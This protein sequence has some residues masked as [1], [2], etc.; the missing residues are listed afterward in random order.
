MVDTSL[1]PLITPSKNLYVQLPE[2]DLNELIALHS[3]YLINPNAK[4]RY[5]GFLGVRAPGTEKRYLSDSGFILQDVISDIYDH[6]QKASL[7]D[8]T[9]PDIVKCSL[10]LSEA[11]GV[12]FFH[13]KELKN[14]LLKQ[15][16][17]ID[18]SKWTESCTLAHIKSYFTKKKE[19]HNSKFVM[20][21]SAYGGN[22]LYIMN[23]KFRRF[24]EPE[25][26]LP[27]PKS[28]SQWLNVVW[29][30]LAA[31]NLVV[32]DS[33]AFI[34][35]HPIFAL[36]RVNVLHKNQI[37]CRILNDNWVKIKL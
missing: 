32:G 14:I 28:L 24:L 18:S 13:K 9:N 10:R 26:T 35:S 16:H 23:E 6:I 25:N 11:L 30:Y 17:M 4:L 22:A 3:T 21:A 34:K 31:Q 20:H 33:I 36:F 7:S 37:I 8:P 5:S 15:A 29:G 19:L 2:N 27:T 12:N 1:T